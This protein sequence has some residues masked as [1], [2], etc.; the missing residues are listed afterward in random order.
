ME[1]LARW[2]S[3]VKPVYLAQ[4]LLKAFFPVWLTKTLHWYMNADPGI[5]ALGE[6]YTKSKDWVPA[7]LSKL[8]LVAAGFSAGLDILNA[9]LSG[10]DLSTLTATMLLQ[11][12]LP[13]VE[14]GVAERKPTIAASTSNSRVPLKEV[15]G[16]VADRHGLV[17]VPA[18]KGRTKE[19][20]P[21]YMFG[22]TSVYVNNA[23]QLVYA[24]DQLGSRFRPM[25]IEE[26]V[27]VASGGSAEGVK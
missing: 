23:D 14:P 9:A 22:K 3:L 10:S 26:L 4:I 12:R 2:D 1:W 17:F 7:S 19:G 21:V 27:A 25:S 16:R 8:P 13:R 18:P 5:E 20:H 15:L 11:R 24:Q 6:W